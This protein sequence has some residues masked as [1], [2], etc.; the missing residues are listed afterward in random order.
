MQKLSNPCIKTSTFAELCNTNK[1]TL[2][3]YDEIGLFS[4]AYTD[5]KGYRYYTESQC[6]VFF[7]ITCLKD[8]GM[9]LKEIKSYIDHRDP[10][11]LRELLL[12]QQ[13]QV[14]KEMEHLNRI[15]QVISTKLSLISAGSEI[16]FQDRCS[17]VFLEDMPEEY[18]IVSP[19]LNTSDQKALFSA[20]SEHIRYCNEHA[21]SV[22]HPYGAMLPV[23]TLF[24]KGP[25]IYCRFLTKISAPPKDPV[26]PLLIKPA[27]QYVV[28]Y[29]KGDYYSSGDAYQKL[30]DYIHSHNLTADTYCYKEAVWDE[31]TVQSPDEYITK[32]SIALR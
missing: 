12:H 23:H 31:L 9:P 3:H 4:P 7:T 18:M 19:E 16:S 22:G 26:H 11:S 24:D 27:G 13:E 32:I 17:D 14:Q 5:E 30:L 2:I 6:D 20:L 28:T 25:D 21:L 10:S 8:L 29:L 15:R 1:R